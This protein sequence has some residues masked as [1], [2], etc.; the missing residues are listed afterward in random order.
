M[1]ISKVEDIKYM[2][3]GCKKE[4]KDKIKKL[5]KNMD[6]NAFLDKE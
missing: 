3:S 4:L 1:I 6:E 2:F 5:Y